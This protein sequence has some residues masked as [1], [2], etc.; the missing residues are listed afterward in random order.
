MSD[1]EARIAEVLQNHMWRGAVVLQGHYCNCGHNGPHR[2]HVAAVLVKE[3]G[4]AVDYALVSDTDDVQEFFTREEMDR[5]ADDYGARW[6]P[7]MRIATSW[8]PL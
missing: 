5:H 4:L 2:E 1:I 3:L 7:S 6:V 8:R